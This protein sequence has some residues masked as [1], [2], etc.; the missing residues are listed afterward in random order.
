M[1][2]DS[3]LKNRQIRASSSGIFVTSTLQ[4]VIDFDSEPLNE[5]FKF[6]VRIIGFKLLQHPALQLM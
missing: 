3:M 1:I 4:R 2:L 5:L 6:G